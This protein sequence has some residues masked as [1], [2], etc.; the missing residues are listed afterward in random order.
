MDARQKLAQNLTSES[1]AY[2]YTLT[3]WGTGAI[4]IDRFGTP[5]MSQISLYVGGALL[6]FAILAF[7]AFQNVIIERKSGDTQQLV[8]VSMI[9]IFATF[10]NLL[11]SGL[12]VKTIPT[13]ILT[14]P[15][16]YLFIGFQATFTYNV[17][18]LVESSLG[19]LL[20]R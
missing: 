20:T 16:G 13:G 3:I 9:H 19:R 15:I 1:E 14:E 6:A 2:G 4:L 5:G 12:L 18:L 11:L 10:G 7:I 17:L 8:V